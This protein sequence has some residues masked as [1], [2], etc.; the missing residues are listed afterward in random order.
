MKLLIK[1]LLF[2][3]RLI[4]FCGSLCWRGITLNF[5]FVRAL[6]PTPG[7]P[8]LLAKCPSNFLDFP[9]SGVLN[10]KGCLPS[11]YFWCSLRSKFYNLTWLRCL[12]FFSSSSF[13][14]IC[15][16][17]CLISSLILGTTLSR[18]G[19]SCTGCDGL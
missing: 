16:S 5:L 10:G 1:L 12:S 13:S 7:S 4:R 17:F 14:I 6:P 15:S 2:V 9:I 11:S 19:N 8:V 18:F 3:L